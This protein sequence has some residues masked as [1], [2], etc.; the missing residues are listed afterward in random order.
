MRRTAAEI[1]DG[2]A[3]MPELV[4]DRIAQLLQREGAEAIVG[5]P[6]NRLLNS[7][8]LLGH[9]PDHHAHRARRGQHRRRLRARHQRRALRP[10]RRRSTARAPRPPSPRSRRP[11]ATAARSCCSRA[12]TPSPCRHR[13]RA[14]QRARVPRR[15]R[16]SRP[17]LN[18]AARGPEVFRRALNALRG[19]RN[20]P[21]LVAIANDVLNGPAGDA[22]W[23]VTT[24]LPRLTQ[25]S[26]DDVAQTAQ[27]AARRRAS[28]DPRGQGVL[29]AGAT[30][31]LVR[32]AELTGTPVAT[33]L[34][35]KSAFPE[36]HPLALGTAGAHAA[37]HRRPT[38]SRR[39][40]SCSASARASR[41]RSTSR[42]CPPARRSGRSRTTAAISRPAT[43]SR[44]AASATRASC[45]CS[46][47]TRSARRA[48]SGA[49][50]RR[51]EV[52]DVRAAFMEQW[53]RAPDLGRLA[54]QPLP[55]RLG[56]DAASS[57][58][59]ARS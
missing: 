5:F 52:A 39:P 51:R 58:A 9:A 3:L 22:D 44:S 53:L 2:G 54:A 6:E 19:A 20:G 42:P 31:E 40:T 37:G 15:S 49:R 4:A 45:C 7:A 16:A 36:N 43:T 57:T 30:A 8:A 50:R 35:G 41:A 59:R 55:R 14:A 32:L 11:T 24:S 34:N 21:V 18:D 17:P 1:V 12:S 38:S 46:C 33:T 25:A 23:D 56:A 29:Y 28:G 13:A 26:A 27:G 10:V 48:A 47:S